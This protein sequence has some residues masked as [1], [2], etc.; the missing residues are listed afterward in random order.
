MET[1]T[2]GSCQLCLSF[3]YNLSSPSAV[4][5]ERLAVLNHYINDKSLTMYLQLAKEDY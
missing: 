1:K 3:M 5:V 4:S 2:N